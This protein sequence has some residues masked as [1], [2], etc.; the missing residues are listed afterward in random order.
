MAMLDKAILGTLRLA[1]VR[2]AKHVMW[3][4]RNNPQ[5]ADRWGYHVREIHYYEPLPDFREITERAIQRRNSMRDVDLNL[6]GQL[7]LL[8]ALASSCRD[9]L[10][11]LQAEV[12]PSAFDFSNDYFSNHDAAIYYALIRH[13]RPQRVLEVGSGYS[14]RI[15]AKAIAKNRE[16]GRQCSLVAIEPYPQPRLLDAKLGIRL[17]ERKVQEVDD[18]EFLSLGA[19]DIL[20]I[21]SSHVAKFDSDVLHLFLN[22]LPQLA[23]GVWVHVHDIFFPVDY[24]RE[25]L[26]DKRIAFNEQYFLH[27]LLSG[28][29]SWR[30][31]MANHLIFTD[32]KELLHA[33]FDSK[34]A[35]ALPPS[36]IWLTK[37]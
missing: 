6:A 20:F 15:A 23:S 19:G 17:V 5:L 34:N 31:A 12:E 1:P 7:Q 30:V 14:T 18:S 26:I 2:L 35:N 4:L 37:R 27:A 8:N 32:Y 33:L 36:G 29:S 3:L 25:W 16:D 10:M 21:D 13:L 28:N 11:A 9:E 24:P 22:V